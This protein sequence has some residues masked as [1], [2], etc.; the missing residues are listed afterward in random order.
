MDGNMLI[1]ISALLDVAAVSVQLTAAFY[2]LKLIRITGKS[3]AWFLICGALALM[4][5]RRSIILYHFFIE[6]QEIDIWDFWDALVALGISGAMLAGVFT[7]KPLFLTIKRAAE[8]LARANE[9]LEMQVAKRTEELRDANNRLAVEL[10]ERRLAQEELARSNTELEQFAYIASHDL[11]EP[12]RM[13]S[14]FTQLLGKRYQGKLDSDADEF[15]SFAADGASRMQRLLNDLLAY[16]RV[17]THGKPLV[18]TDCN[19]ILTQTLANLGPL[20]KES[21]AVITHDPLP[22]VQGD[23][24]QLIQ[25]FQNLLANAIKFRSQEAPRIRV[26]AEQKDSEWRFAVRDNGIGIAPEHQQRIF[27]I[28]QRL[29]QRADYPGTGIGL[30]LCKKIVERHKGRIWVESKLGQGSTF[31]FTLKGGEHDGN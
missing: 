16:S 12:L 30:A 19:S 23:E 25:L 7:I 14:S 28:F 9:E 20:I 24:V 5:A 18:P 10:E 17:G 2:A 6:P 27:L 8:T 21:G 15:I 26:S 31:Y 1:G 22:K 3:A 11:Q 4:A 13:V 29:H